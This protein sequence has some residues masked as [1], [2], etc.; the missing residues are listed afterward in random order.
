MYLDI[1]LEIT[2][3]KDFTGYTF[4]TP[5]GFGGKNYCS[6]CNDVDYYFNEQYQDEYNKMYKNIRRQYK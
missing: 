1:H 4:K 3:N 5:K 2:M 6:F